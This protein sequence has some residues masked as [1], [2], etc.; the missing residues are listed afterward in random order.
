[1]DE[2][3]WH[4]LSFEETT[5]ILK[6]DIKEGLSEK[7]VKI[8][9]GKFGKNSLP[10][11][12][13]L[14]QLRIFLEQFKSPLIYILVI[15]GTSTLILKDL[16]DAIVIFGAVFLNTVVGYFQENKTSKILSELK[17]VVKVKTYAVREGNEKEIDQ[18]EV[19]PGDIIL[20]QPGNKIPADGRL[21]ES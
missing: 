3:K 14:P 21:V 4:N 9:Q 19:V 1:M 6:I 13:P 10:E 5:K 11:E 12:K 15:A 16:T 20:L 8:R 18:S 2:K 7:E 17:K